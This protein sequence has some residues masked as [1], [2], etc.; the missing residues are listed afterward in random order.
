MEE[1]IKIIVT[2]FCENEKNKYPRQMQKLHDSITLSSYMTV[3]CIRTVQLL[4]TSL[5]R[6]YLKY[7][8]LLVRA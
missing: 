7:K 6:L 5:I 2:Y 1:N 4:Y 8:A 3:D